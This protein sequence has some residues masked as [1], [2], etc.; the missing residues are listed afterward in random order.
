M[1]TRRA[2]NLT[3]PRADLTRDSPWCVLGNHPVCS[4]E[5]CRCSCHPER[6]I[7][8]A[9]FAAVLRRLLSDTPQTGHGPED[10]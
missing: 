6:P 1:P 3:D 5:G 2:P 4:D 9:G 7:T 8:S 10:Y